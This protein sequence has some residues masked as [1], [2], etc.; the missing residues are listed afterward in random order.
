MYEGDKWGVYTAT[1]TLV[2]TEPPLKTGLLMWRDFM[3]RF[4]LVALFAVFLAEAVWETGEWPRYFAGVKTRTLVNVLTAATAVIAS[5]PVFSALVGK[6]YDGYRLVFLLPLES[7][8]A[9]AG[10][11]IVDKPSIGPILGIWWGFYWRCALWQILLVIGFFVYYFFVGVLFTW[12]EPSFIV[13]SVFQL[14]G[15]LLLYLLGNTLVF[16]KVFG[17][18]MDRETFSGHRLVLLKPVPP[19]L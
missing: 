1:G 4:V 8:G 9:A 10:P 3:W 7:T 19:L 13:E 6:T 18:L 15:G 12:F 11:R 2:E 17:Q 5:I 14:G 16:I